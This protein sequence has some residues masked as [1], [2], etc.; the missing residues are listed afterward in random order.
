MAGSWAP[1]I[2]LQP[3]PQLYFQAESSFPLDLKSINTTGNC[4]G[5]SWI[6]VIAGAKFNSQ[7]PANL[8][9]WC[10]S[11][12]VQVRSAPC[13]LQGTVNFPLQ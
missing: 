10:F 8:P 13:Q 1:A 4:R 12:D 7:V 3:T 5:D 6:S 11:P 2:A 9:V